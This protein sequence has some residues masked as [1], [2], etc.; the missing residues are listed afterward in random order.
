MEKNKAQS[1]AGLD[2]ILAKAETTAVCYECN[3]E[4]PLAEWK[5]Y[6]KMCQKCYEKDG[7]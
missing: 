4:I 3:K 2:N 7:E 6:A 5:E 1:I